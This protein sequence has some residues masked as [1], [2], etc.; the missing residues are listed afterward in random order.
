MT[1][2]PR[3]AYAS[4][5]SRSSASARGTVSNT[6]LSNG[7]LTSIFLDLSTQLPARN[8]FI[9]FLRSLLAILYSLQGE[10]LFLRQNGLIQSH[11]TSRHL[12]KP[13]ITT[14]KLS[15][16]GI[17]DRSQIITVLSQRISQVIERPNQKPLQED[18]GNP[19]DQWR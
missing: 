16:N 11:V 1:L 12:S 13:R 3:S 10:L 7:F 19:Y 5:F 18:N 15:G 14:P 9:P 4:A 2:A 17:S 8:I 6:E